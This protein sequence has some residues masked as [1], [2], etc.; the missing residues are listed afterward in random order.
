MKRIIWITCFLFVG[1]AAVQAQ[2]T[3]QV[4]EYDL[5][6]AVPREAG[7]NETVVI[8]KSL[9]SL[10]FESTMDKTVEIYDTKEESGFTFYYLKF[11]T[12]P[13]YKGRKLKIRSNLYATET[14]PLNL[15]AKVPLGIY[16]YDPSGTVGVGCYFE[17]RNKGNDFYVQ[18]DYDNAKSEYL[19]ALECADLPEE[20]DL[21]QKLEDSNNCSDAKRTADN[22]YNEEKWPEAIKDYE[23]VIGLN[24]QDEYCQRRIDDCVLKIATMP[25]V[26]TGKVI[27]SKGAPL[28]GVTIKSIEITTDSKGKEKETE[29]TVGTTDKNGE[30]K[31]TVQYKHKYLE[32]SKGKMGSA[33]VKNFLNTDTSKSQEVTYNKV[34]PEIVGDVINI[35][36]TQNILT[37]VTGELLKPVETK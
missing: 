29:T 21:A 7:D 25:R 3:M 1:M 11:N 13:K 6:M 34:K 27:D 12:L 17:H 14:Y 20:N 18:A 8:V 10:D 33:F 24:R 23:K 2:R 37:D 4:E 15:V 22:F 32:F 5:G 36:M 28:S 30:Y 35:T 16:V 31:V 26:I 19:L 9:L